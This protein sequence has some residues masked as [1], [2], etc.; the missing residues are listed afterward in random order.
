MEDQAEF[1]RHSKAAREKA[2]D[3]LQKLLTSAAGHG[4]LP[5]YELITEIR[6]CLVDV[7]GGCAGVG[8]LSL[9]LSDDVVSP[10]LSG[11]VRF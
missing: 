1:C 6:A 5:R 8:E 7:C 4:R 11:F 2:A 10:G 3:S 9:C